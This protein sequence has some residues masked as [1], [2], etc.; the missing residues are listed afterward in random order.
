M[1]IFAPILIIIFLLTAACALPVTLT[2]GATPV[3]V[4]V[5]ATLIAIGVQ[6]TLSALSPNP[7]DN[8]SAT[9]AVLPPAVLPTEPVAQVNT[10]LPVESHLPKVTMTGGTGYI[11]STGQVTVDDRDIWWNALQFV[12]ASGYRMVLLGQIGSPDSIQGVTFPKE[13]PTTHTISQG[14]GYA[15]EL[16]RDGKVEYAVLRVLSID[17]GMAVTFDLVYPY[18]GEVIQ[19]P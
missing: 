12:P 7:A 2:V 8:L 10:P 15:V 14:E 18:L 16:K 5:E 3:P 9:E 19:L 13:T 4:D 11:F 1:K 17:S 6:Q